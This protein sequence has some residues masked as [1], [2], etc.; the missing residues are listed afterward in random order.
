MHD[1]PVHFLAVSLDAEP[2]RVRVAAETLKVKLPVAMAES[3]LL[4][5]LHL[6]TVPATIFIDSS[7]KVVAALHTAGKA[8]FKAR[9]QQ[10][11][12]LATTAPRTGER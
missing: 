12:A 10:L 9:A 2:K 3:E 1:S 6:E 11:L 5:P 8:D 7:G 4:D